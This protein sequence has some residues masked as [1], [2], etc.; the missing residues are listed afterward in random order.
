MIPRQTD[1]ILATAAHLFGVTPA[2][3][4]GPSRVAHIAEVRHALAWVLRVELGWTLDAIGG[5]LGG[6]DHTTIMYSIARAHA[7][8]D[9]HAWFGERVRQLTTLLRDDPVAIVPKPACSCVCAARLAELE[10][11]IARLEERDE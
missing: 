9:T 8:K 5:L 7:R 2:D 3:I 11:R 4:P 10:S 1:S 6:R